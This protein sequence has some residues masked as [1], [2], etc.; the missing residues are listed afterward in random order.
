MLAG[1]DPILGA[2]GADGAS[3]IWRCNPDNPTGAVTP[4]AE[5]VELARRHPDAA[6]VVDEAYV[7]YGGETVVPWLGECPNLVVLRT[8]SKA[9]GYAALRVGYA[10]AA[11]ATAAV[12]EARRAPAPIAAPAA[13][14]AAA[15]LRDPRYDLAPELA[16]RERVREAL[17]AAGFDA[18]PVAGNFVWIR[19]EDDLGARLEQQGI[20]VRRFP[21]GIRV[22]LRRP[23]ENDL[24]LRALGAE[25]G[26]PP[27]REATLIRTS[28]ETALRITLSLDGSGRS[29]VAT[30][31]GFL[32][33]LLTLLAFHA[34]FDL[35]C[36]A[37][38]DLE[39]D[40]HHTVEDVLAAFGSALQQA[41]GARE[42][43]AR[44]GSAVVPMDEARAMAAVDLVRRP[45]AEIS[46]AFTG[47]R[48]GG[49]ALSLLPH[50][51]ERFTM[52]AGCTV[53]VEVD[54]G[55]RPPCRRGR[56]QGP[57]PGAAA[58]GRGRRRRHP[59]HQGHRV[60]VVLADYGAGNLRSVT[61]AF[62][63]AGAEASIT[64]DAD[65]VREAPLAV[66]A[67]VGHVESA[68]RGLAANGLDEAIRDRIAAGKPVLGICVGM[69]LLFG[70]SEEGGTGLELL[71]GPVRRVR[72]RRV[73]HMGW[74]DLSVTRP[75]ALV[76]GLDGQD[77][78]FA[79]SFAVE[80]SD[81]R[82]VVA[83]A[84]HDGRVVAAVEQGAVAGVQ[85]HPERSA[86]AGARLLEN[87]LAWSRSA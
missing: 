63:R 80:P 4:A 25:P 29:H 58:G 42:G 46:L 78:Y 50:A 62:A 60:K 43:V 86:A 64:T 18:P 22:T 59:L 1:A 7:E 51:L 74:N 76:E 33:H 84:D 61:S 20:I 56:V 77:V 82:V 54:R 65:A 53:H 35:D 55:R 12:L 83:A 37:G 69:Q 16:E 28:T 8:M 31:I 66:I 23:T 49:L 34:G 47:E 75:S 87:A 79:H 19:S 17:V 9:F 72:A 45:H 11:P 5:L 36:V 15:A 3:L 10:V 52:E 39:V 48:V 81:E 70:E 41:L 67:G 57:R 26:P 68:A 13:R 30:G 44:Y 27:G 21:E 73:P 40:E 24:F 71:D 2:D 32:D 14:I 6:V 38:G 85:F